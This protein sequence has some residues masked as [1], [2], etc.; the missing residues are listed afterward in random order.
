ML[1]GVNKSLLEIKQ[2]AMRFRVF[3]SVTG[4]AESSDSMNESLGG[5]MTRAGRTAKP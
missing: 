5:R 1:R 4:K 3:F 2:I